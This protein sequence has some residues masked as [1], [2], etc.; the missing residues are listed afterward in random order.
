MN[1]KEEHERHLKE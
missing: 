1:K